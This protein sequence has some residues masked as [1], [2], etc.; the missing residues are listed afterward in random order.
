[1]STDKSGPATQPTGR[2]TAANEIA[3]FFKQRGGAQ[4]RLR[5]VSGI[6]DFNIEGAGRWRVTVKDGVVSATEGGPDTP[7][8]DCVI[9]C[10][11]QDFQRILHREG[12]MNMVT[13]TLQ[14]LITVTG[15]YPFAAT[16]I[17]NFEFEPAGS[18]S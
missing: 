10:A 14:E 1:M 8:A 18:P 6:C 7:P 5:G 16:L 4:P 2:G 17:G 11:A 13:A 3:A 9:T 12:N 15:D